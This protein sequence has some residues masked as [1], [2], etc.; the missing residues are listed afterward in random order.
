[1]KNYQDITKK[2]C[3]GHTTNPVHVERVLYSLTILVLVT[4]CATSQE[5]NKIGDS[6]AKRVEKTEIAPHSPQNSSLTLGVKTTSLLQAIGASTLAKEG[7]F[8]GFGVVYPSSNQRSGL[9]GINI[10][11]HL[12]ARK[13]QQALGSAAISYNNLPDVPNDIGEKFLYLPDDETTAKQPDSGGSFI[14]RRQNVIITAG[15]KGSMKGAIEFARKIDN[16][17]LH[18]DVICP[19]GKMVPTPEIELTFPD[20]IQH[21]TQPQVQ[22]KTKDGSEV[23]VSN[24]SSSSDTWRAAGATSYWAKE[25]G[26]Q[27]A[28]FTFATRDNVIFTKSVAVN[29]LSKQ[30]MAQSLEKQR[31]EFSKLLYFKDSPE[32][33]FGALRQREKEWINLEPGTLEA[34]QDSA[35]VREQALKDLNRIVQDRWLPEKE[36]I[37]AYYDH[38]KK[39]SHEV[40]SATFQVQDQ[41]VIYWGV[42]GKHAWLYIE[43]DAKKR[44][45]LAVKDIIRPEQLKTVAVNDESKPGV[46][47]RRFNR[48]RALETSGEWEHVD[49]LMFH[50]RFQQ[51]FDLSSFGY[52]FPQ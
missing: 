40:Y 4:G 22:Y 3:L 20:K 38:W 49:I 51:S 1:M 28:E 45:S 41:R 39:V 23:L 5:R 36:F 21:G 32:Q 27:Q 15:W 48:Y 29:V 10:G 7:L 47:S 50:F 34:L 25:L 12:S 35:K 26:Q 33:N 13:A 11:V 30:E 44:K 17:L 24:A 9:T 52:A 8:G 37:E 46:L 43:H 18:S 14:L 31:W 2:T 6:A 42:P 16:I 19:K